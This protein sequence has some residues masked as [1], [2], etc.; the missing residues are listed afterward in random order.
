MFDN[1]QKSTK[2]KWQSPN[3]WWHILSPG[4]SESKTESDCLLKRNRDKYQHRSKYQHPSPSERG[5]LSLEE[6]AHPCLGFAFTLWVLPT[7][8][9]LELLPSGEWYRRG[10]G[11]FKIWGPMEGCSSLISYAIIKCT[12]PLHLIASNLGKKGLIWLIILVTVYHSGGAG[13][14]QP[15]HFHRQ[16]LK[17]TNVSMML[18]CSCL[19]FLILIQSRALC[20]GKGV[21][22]T[23]LDQ[24]T[25]KLIPHRHAYRLK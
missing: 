25:V 23:G 18:A 14:S 12:P 11:I 1:T 8:H 13:G 7:V 15:C 6:S 22:Q 17:E 16:E 19:A 3:F 21:T 5:S 24:L 4:V 9:V 2:K 20:L 10:W